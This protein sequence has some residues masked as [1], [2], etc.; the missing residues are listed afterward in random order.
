[1]SLS[2]SEALQTTQAITLAIAILGA[3]LGLI[4][5]WKAYD[6]DRVKIR[7]VPA[8]AFGVGATPL[9]EQPTLCMKII[10]L[11][12]F[13]VTISEVGFLLDGSERRLV[14]GHPIIVDDGPFPRRLD[15]RTAFT[16]YCAP[17]TERE[18]KFRRVRAAFASTDLN[19]VFT[20]RSKMLSRVAT[21]GE[22]ITRTKRT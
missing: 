21:T 11:S 20:G 12:A 19:E 8:I 15:A 2:R 16:V 18:A 13:A 17:G 4:N 3:V 1:M 6:R 10:N 5:T 7:V 22:L 9:G 14:I